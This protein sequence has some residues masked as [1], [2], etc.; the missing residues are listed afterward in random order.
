MGFRQQMMNMMIEGK[1]PEDIAKLMMPQMMEKM[2]PADMA[3]IMS[4]MMP[5]MMDNC[6]SVMD[7]ER[8]KSMLSHCRSML[9]HMEAKHLGPA[10]T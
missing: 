7:V 2:G 6:F 9:D 3:L 5:R 1:S 10:V 4:E 8:C